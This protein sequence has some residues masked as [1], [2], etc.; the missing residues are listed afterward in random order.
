MLSIFRKMPAVALALAMAFT[1]VCVHGAYGADA[2]KKAKTSGKTMKNSIPNTFEQP[3]FAFPETVSANASVAFDKAMKGGDYTRAL[4]ALMQLT[5]SQ[6]SIDAARRQECIERIDSVARIMPEPYRSVGLLMEASSYRT[7]Y[8]R[9]RWQYDQRNLPLDTV[10][11]DITLWSKDLYA[12]KILSLVEQSAAGVEAAARLPLSALGRLTTC[13]DGVVNVPTVADFMDYEGMTLLSGFFTVSADV[14]PFRT[15]ARVK[16]S[17][18]DRCRRQAR[19]MGGCAM[20]RAAEAGDAVAYCYAALRSSRLYEGPER[21]VILDDA[22]RHLSGSPYCVD[23][24]DAIM[25][26]SDL[27]VVAVDNNSSSDKDSLQQAKVQGIVARGDSLLAMFPDAHGAHALANRLNELK[28][29]Y[30]NVRYDNHYMSTDSVTVNVTAHN[31]AGGYLL[32][33]RLPVRNSNDPTIRVVLSGGSLQ[34]AVPYQAAGVDAALP[35]AKMLDVTFGRLPYGLY[36]VVPSSTRNASGVRVSDMRVSTFLVSDMSIVTT[37]SDS[38]DGSLYVVDGASQ[39]PL[40]GQPVSLYYGNGYRRG[41]MRYYESAGQETV[42][43]TDAD[44]RCLFDNNK[45]C[46]IRVKRGNDTFIAEVPTRWFGRDKLPEGRLSAKILTDLSLYRPGE[47]VQFA[48]VTYTRTGRTM[49]SASDRRLKAVLIDANGENRDT[50]TLCTDALGR[51]EGSFVLPEGGLLGT[52]SLAVG[53]EDSSEPLASWQWRLG[54]AYFEVA[55]YKAPTFIVETDGVECKPELGKP[56]TVTGR[57]RTYSGMPVAGAM[58]GYAVRY[59]SWWLW[60]GS[61]SASEFGGN[62]TTDADGRFRITLDTDGLRD[63]PY[64]LGAYQ[65]TVSATSEAGET[66]SGEPVTFSFGSAYRISLPGE[67]LADAADK[68]LDIPARVTDVIGKPVSAELT[69]VL[70]DKS[71]VKVAS[72]R[73]DAPTLC[74]DISALPSARYR[75]AVAMPDEVLA[76]TAACDVVVYRKDD[77]KPPYETMLWLPQRA[78]KAPEGVSTV[79][80]TIGSSYGDS[81]VLCVV[82]DCDKVLSRQWIKIDNRNVSIEVPV[83]AYDNTVFVTL[84][85]MRGLRSSRA[86]VSVEPLARTQP[87]TIEA[88]SFRDKIRSGSDERWT[89]RFTRGGRP[90]TFIPVMAVMSNKA[91]NAITPFRWNFS[92]RS[93]IYFRPIVSVGGNDVNYLSDRFEL[94]S[95]KYLDIEKFRDPVFDSYGGGGAMVRSTSRKLYA[96]N[97]IKYENVV[98]QVYVTGAIDA[99]NAA[100]LDLMESEVTED[101]ADAGAGAGDSRQ[102]EDALRDVECPLAFFMPM[103]ATDGE[104][105]AAL[106]FRAPDFNTTWQLQVMGYEPDMSTSQ[107]VLDIVSSKPVMVQTTLPRFLRTGDKVT[108]AATVYNATAEPMPVG[109]RIEIF[110]A[111][112]GEIVVR[113]EYEYRRVDAAGSRVETISYDVPDDVA[114]IGVRAYALAEG[115]SDGEQTLLPVLPSSSPVIESTPFYIGT[116]RSGMEVALP[117]YPADAT[118]TLQYCANP[119]WYCVTALP[120][121]STPDTDCLSSLLGALYGNCIADRLVSDY[122]QLRDALAY[123]KED[124]LA[125]GDSTLISNLQKNADLKTVLLSNT[126]WVGNAA[127]ETLRMERLG[128]LLDK[129]ATSAA[130]LRLADK[131]KSM[132]QPDGGFSWCPGMKSSEFITGMALL[133][134]AMLE[135]MRCLP[136]G[137]SGQTIRKAIAYVDNEIVRDWRRDKVH[138]SP[139]SM[140]NY[141]YIRSFFEALPASAEF[142]ALKKRALAEIADGWRGYGVYEKSTAATLLAR[143]GYDMAARSIL[144]SLSQSAVADESRGMQFAN[145]SSGHDGWNRLISTAQALEAFGEIEPSSPCVDGLRQWLVM[146]REAQDWG[147]DSYTAEIIYAILTSGSDWTSASADADVS[148]GGVDVSIPRRDRLTGAF[149]VNIPAS[150]ASGKVLKVDRAGAS[151]AW[152]SVV[153]R[154]IS[155]MADVKAASISDLSVTKSVYKVSEGNDGTVLLDE[156]LHKGDKVRVTIN[157]VCAR[158]LDYVAVT[159]ERPACLEPVDNISGYGVRD[160]LWMYRETRDSA[161]NMFLGF[162]P[163]GSHV[164]TY[165][166]Y[167]QQEGEFAQG[168]ATVQSQYAPQITAHSAGSIVRVR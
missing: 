31:S 46:Y 22:C 104:G 3:D 164:I 79:P 60:R 44:G 96:A 72:G 126:P 58:V 53:L 71:G 109:C 1:G 59:V 69:Y 153:S 62:V 82:S 19:H 12:L 105:V 160:G 111:I 119:V 14:I 85:A 162:L 136:A 101:E 98:D 142:G 24:Y 94:N 127:S 130:I 148:I 52:W 106:S 43:K 147:D 114:A 103:L 129:S 168:I 92:P 70:S 123:W 50:V 140:L 135:K 73:F 146:Q 74:L 75:L 124:A 29:K 141:L 45:N 21:R 150:E 128:E 65:M 161:T 88:E 38:G 138:F 49:Q 35:F 54:N 40:A 81:Y 67:I 108:F 56:L 145:L 163:K 137:L 13:P 158:D 117:Q 99:A 159:D 28:R 113:R 89:F 36:A 68:K 42:V 90:C 4:V 76:D 116:T 25:A 165:D 120:D 100:P 78:L 134:F 144:E 102:G 27:S 33:Y 9:E 122:P 112:S 55:E 23:I 118:L 77:A 121:I 95:F 15:A 57:V 151:P 16:P 125:A 84:S 66:Q 149:R 18:G 115:Y 47:R 2:P 37:R 51:A 107:Q 5:A 34:A 41:Q 8:D 17:L 93:E 156:P 10:P 26:D 110:D 7:A 48:V 154:Y 61:D 166:C 63:T 157:V 11:D 80:L 155:P 39:Q 30:V 32:L 87:V 131:I 64:G 91:L 139:A 6:T 97:E 143:S 20:K 152:G 86:T 132:Q 83:P 133:H 167:V